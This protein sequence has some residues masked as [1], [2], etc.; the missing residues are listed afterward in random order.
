MSE[1]EVFVSKED[2]KF[3]CAHFIAHKNFRER[4]HGHNYT[5]AV[6]LRG[7]S[8]VSTDGYLLDFGDLKKATRE[9]CKSIGEYFICPMKSDSLI[10]EINGSQL[11]M[12]CTDGTKF[13]FPLADCAL[14]PIV[15]SSAE[16]LAHWF[17]CSLVR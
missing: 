17:W 12:E 7:G 14:L 1:F 13:Q 16:E 4:L 6:T 11:C 2:F 9:L 10:I 5:V 8:N 3:S 15:H